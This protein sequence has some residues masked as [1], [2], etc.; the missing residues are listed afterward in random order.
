MLRML[1]MTAPA[2]PNDA[3]MGWEFTATMIVTLLV[4]RLGM[5]TSCLGHSTTS[6][7]LS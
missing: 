4:P 6:A 2:S 7:P 1:P 5:Y 3:T